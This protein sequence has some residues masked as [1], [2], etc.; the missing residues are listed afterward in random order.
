MSR[1][2]EEATTEA[3]LT[4]GRAGRQAVQDAGF[5]E[6][7]KEKL[8]DKVQGA[9]FRNQ[10]S[11]VFATAGL[12]ATPGAGSNSGPA[13]SQPWTGEERT[14]DAVLRMLDDAKKPLRPGLRG[15]FQPPPV[16]MRIRRDPVLSPSE[17]VASAR[18]KAS[19]Y[20]GMGLKER[21]PSPSSKETRKKEKEVQG[22]EVV[23][24]TDEEKEQRR[25]HFR[26]RFQPGARAMPN[27][28]SG[29]AALANE[30]IENA[31][32]R[33]QFK[34]IPRG[35]GI[36]RDTRADNPFID[37]TEYIMNK[38]IQRQDIVPPW[39]EKQQDLV[40][41][42][43]TFRTRLRNDW[44]RHAARMIASRGGSLLAQMSR[45][46]AYARSESLHN[47][48]QRLRKVEDIPISTSLTDDPVMVKMR[49][50][51]KQLEEDKAAVT[52]AAAAAAT[53]TVRAATSEKP[54]QEAEAK[55]ETEAAPAPLPP[56]FRDPEW[57]KAESKYMQ[58]S[59]DNLN[60][61][62]RAYNLMAPDLA[63]KPYYSLQR[64]LLSA[65]ADVAPQL[66][67]E[68]KE[69]ATR[70]TNPGLGAAPGGGN[71]DGFLEYLG[72]GANP[73]IHLEAD[74]KAYGLK[75][76]WRDFWSKG[77]KPV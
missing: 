39:I 9:K 4:G 27:S 43:H 50:Q 32:A 60:S 75:E 13:V 57:E 73:R 67:N 24:L 58:L 1:R 42:A 77:S 44:K 34:N 55:P 54:G 18:D 68:I 10:F 22:E 17:R 66:A 72:G 12:P 48:M 28:I 11:S 40:K 16:D 26:E 41:A 30:R 59:I 2:L 5:S 65:Y 25:Q 23:G 61:I 19:M 53:A 37:T 56:P 51:V 15:K 45:A 46:E 74:E 8:F 20:S 70:P 76:W 71:K 21:L 7:L 52:E 69:R 3:L 47:P 49:Q 64:E 62:T 29:L 63:K 6:E 36:E 33:G 35:K 14:E 31:I 38:M